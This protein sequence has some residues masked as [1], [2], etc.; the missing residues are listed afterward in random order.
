LTN[1]PKYDILYTSQGNTPRER[2]EN[3]MTKAEL[4]KMIENFDD[5]A[6][7]VFI[8]EGHDRDGYP[9]DRTENIYKVVTT[10]AKRVRKEYG[11]HRYEEGE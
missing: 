5:N 10:K 6:E 1:Y 4:M 2:E 7:L 8:Y 3:K 11:I 9:E